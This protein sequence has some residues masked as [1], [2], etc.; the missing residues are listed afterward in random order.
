MPVNNKFF[1]Y[2]SF[3][4]KDGSEIRFWEDSWLGNAPLR[5]QY[6]TLYNIARN[7]SDSIDQVLGSFPLNVSFRWD[8]VGIRLASWQALQERLVGIHLVPERDEFRWNLLNNGQ[9]SV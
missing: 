3:R 9:F 7:K 5:E 1:R 2:G 8:L 6:P 4:I